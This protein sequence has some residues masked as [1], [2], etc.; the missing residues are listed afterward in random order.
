MSVLT[1]NSSLSQDQNDSFITDYQALWQPCYIFVPGSGDNAMPIELLSTIRSVFIK[2]HSGKI[3]IRFTGANSIV[4]HV[5]GTMVNGD[6]EVTDTGAT[7]VVTKNATFNVACSEVGTITI[8]S[9]DASGGYSVSSSVDLYDSDGLIAIPKDTAV[10]SSAWLS[11]TG[12]TVTISVNATAA[13]ETSTYPIATAG[14]I[15]L[16]ELSIRDYSVRYNADPDAGFTELKVP[17]GVASD[18]SSPVYMWVRNHWGNMAS[19][20]LIRS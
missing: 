5:N 12:Q 7:Q 18:S 20:T 11:K 1:S 3:F 6:S 4:A 14:T 15:A 17:R 19:I 8:T 2:S 13:G 10:P 9:T 16:G